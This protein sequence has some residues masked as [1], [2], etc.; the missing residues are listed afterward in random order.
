MH[1]PRR[2]AWDICFPHNLQKGADSPADIDLGFPVSRTVH[3]FVLISLSAVAA[4]PGGI[5]KAAGNLAS[6]ASVLI[7]L[8]GMYMGLGHAQQCAPE[9]KFSIHV[10]HCSQF[11]IRSQITFT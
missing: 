3:S 2:D 11:W 1:T 8:L 10:S 7:E 9:S 6:E 4:L 5:I